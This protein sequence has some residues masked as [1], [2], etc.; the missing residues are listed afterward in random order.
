MPNQ[1]F[2][3]I[4]IRCRSYYVIT[5]STNGNFQPRIDESWFQALVRLIACQ[6]VEPTKTD[7]DYLFQCELVDLKGRLDEI[8]EQGRTIVLLIDE[9]N[10]MGVP[11]DADTSSFLTRTFLDRKGR[12][13]VFSSHVQFHVDNSS[14]NL[15]AANVLTS[16]SG[17]TIKTLP[18]PFC[19]DSTV[20]EDMLGGSSVTDLKITLSVGIP[21]LV[22]IMSRPSRKEMTF[23]QR[24]DDVVQHHLRAGRGS[25]EELIFLSKNRER[26]LYDFIT[27]I[28]HGTRGGGFFEGFSTPVSTI[29]AS[30]VEQRQFRFPLPYIPIILQFLG[31]ED[32]TGLYE[33][34]RA[35]AENVETGR[36]WELVVAFSIYIRSL[37]A[38]YCKATACGKL[39]Q[40]P[41]SIATNG[42]IDVKVITIPHDKTNVVEAVEF[43][44]DTM[45]EA[46][47]IYLFQLAYSKFPDFDGFVSYKT[48]KRH[49]GQDD[50]GVLTIHGYQ[51]KLTRGYPRHAVDCHNIV[52]GWFLRGGMTVRTPVH[53]GWEF[54]SIAQIESD[55]L[56]F[57]LRLLHPMAW[58]TVVESDDFDA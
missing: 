50:L 16:P 29:V 2:I 18:L 5:I 4:I 47:T 54:P 21:S 10:K 57:G 14:G 30:S 19:T 25:Q 3:S 36:D 43:I 8:N 44:K 56:G 28:I 46:K 33:S 35:S 24:F 39:L 7:T 49:E 45:Q 51:C 22:F 52:K 48:L 11:L 27:T 42:V 40:G 31:E 9:L 41:F 23:Q 17:R 38:K 32:A 34:L 12:Y 55:L 58:G 37:E 20:L 1:M 26:L 53:D 6:M 13:L 15:G